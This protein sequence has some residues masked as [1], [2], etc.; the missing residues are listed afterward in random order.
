MEE[1]KKKAD[2]AAAAQAAKDAQAAQVAPPPPVAQVAPAHIAA[3]VDGSLFIQRLPNKPHFVVN[4]SLVSKTSSLRQ[5][6]KNY[7]EWF[8]KNRRVLQKECSEIIKAE[9]STLTF[10][11]YLNKRI[12]Q[13][14]NPPTEEK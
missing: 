7:F 13:F 10:D 2:A 12:A 9:D 3:P 1:A 11:K 14:C 5:E 4:T 8:E 6:I